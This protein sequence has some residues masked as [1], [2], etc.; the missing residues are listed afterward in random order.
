MY[1]LS[2]NFTVECMCVPAPSV[3]PVP[4][5]VSATQRSIAI[6]WDGIDCIDGN[7]P[8]ITYV[9]RLDGRETTTTSYTMAT[10]TNLNPMT[11]YS[12]DVRSQNPSGQ[13]PF[14]PALSVEIPPPGMWQIV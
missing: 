5:L 6:H 11:T 14:G 2:L 13:G 8:M 9:V 7:G 4:V 12:V 10:F 3:G 1:I